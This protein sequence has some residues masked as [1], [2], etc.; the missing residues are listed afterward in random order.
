MENTIE[1]DVIHSEE[2]ILNNTKFNVDF[3]PTFEEYSMLVRKGYTKDD[4]FSLG[5][6]P[7]YMLSVPG[8]LREKISEIEK[9]T[10]SIRID[11]LKE[12]FDELQLSDKAHSYIESRI[13]YLAYLLSE[14]GIEV[15]IEG[16]EYR[17]KINKKIETIKNYEKRLG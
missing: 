12:L 11:G 13:Y 6:A 17:N 14:Q 4:S 9:A 8:G 5:T 1:Y 16:Q 3:I 15:R 10:R 2:Y 7:I